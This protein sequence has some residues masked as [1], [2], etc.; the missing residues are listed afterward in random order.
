M[1]PKSVI[2]ECY[3]DSNLF[4][5]LLKFEKEGVNHSKGN[6]TV[7]EKMK[8]RSNL[9]LLGVIDRDKRS[10]KYIDKE[11]K[12]IEIRSVNDYCE[13]FK[14]NNKPHYI[15]RIVP[16]IETW[17]VNVANSLKVNLADF[18][19]YANDVMELARITKSVEAKNDQRFR[20]LFKTIVKAAEDQNFEP[21]LK[22]RTIANLILEKNYKLDINELING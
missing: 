19:I 15:I 21:V 8:L 14:V 12:K 22:L 10:L 6:A 5:V 2:P 9:C 18:G 4:N 11:C 20:S 7:I 16:E 3:I 17:I 13:I 1:S